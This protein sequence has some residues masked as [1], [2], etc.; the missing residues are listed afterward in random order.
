MSF[1]EIKQMKETE[2]KKYV[3][4][5][6]EET[7]LKYLKSQIKRKGKEIKYKTLELQ[8]YL[9]PEANLN[10]KEKKSIFKI[11]TRMIDIK[12]NFKNK[13]KNF[14]C[15]ACKLKGIN[16]TETQ[17][18][19]YKC[20]ELNKT[21]HPTSTKYKEIFRNDIKQMKKI[22]DQIKRNLEKRNKLK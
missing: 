10:I 15:D 21:E 6:I 22:H 1:E 5:K 8:D 19:I 11:R 12:E 3:K 7:A 9:R 2:F 20:K 14:K 13:H 17:K 16:K 4:T 18:H